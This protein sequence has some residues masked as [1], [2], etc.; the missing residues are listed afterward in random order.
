M[1]LESKEPYYFSGIEDRSFTSKE[2][3]YVNF[4]RYTFIADD[5]AGS[6]L[7]LGSRKPLLSQGIKKFT[8]CYPVIEL[9]FNKDGARALVIDLLQVEDE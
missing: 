5:E 1:I 2:G 7:S 6:A 8:L 4:Y 9:T 3:Q